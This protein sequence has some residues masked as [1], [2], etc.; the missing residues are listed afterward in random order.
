MLAKS[1]LG[2]ILLTQIDGV[3]TSG[4]IVETEAY[5]GPDDKGCHAYNN[6]RTERTKVMYE[7]GGVAYV[8][9]CYGMHP[10]F[11]I[12]TG[13]KESAHAILVRAIEPVEGIETM[14]QRRNLN[15]LTPTLVNGPSKLAVALGIVK[16]MDGT[17]LVKTDGIIQIL[18]NDQTIDESDI[19]EG[20]RVGMSIH[21]GPCAHK[22]WRFYIKE[23]RW[24]S[25]PL[26]VDYT[27]MFQN[28]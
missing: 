24:V 17:T 18:D 14:L 8:Y 3:T 19:T 22:P 16:E 2:K 15:K 13:P 27:K 21:V 1:F 11:N 5:R 6:R 10:M 25:K 9:I 20:P 28:H 4:I 12:V 23:N 26:Q 7:E